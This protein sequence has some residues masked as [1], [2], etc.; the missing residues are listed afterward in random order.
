MQKVDKALL[1][2][3]T[4]EVLRRAFLPNAL[5]VPFVI[6]LHWIAIS[7]WYSYNY[8]HQDVFTNIVIGLLGGSFTVLTYFFWGLR[9]FLIKAYLIIHHNIVQLWLQPF[10]KKNGGSYFARRLNE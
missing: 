3:T 9:R 4:K 1:I 2:S 5:L 10:C 6:L 7:I 8:D